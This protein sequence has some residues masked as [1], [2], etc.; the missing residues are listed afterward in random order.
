MT[1]EERYEVDMMAEKD[2]L[3]KMYIIDH[4]DWAFENLHLKMLEVKIQDYLTYLATE[5]AAQKYPQLE[6]V[7]IEIFFMK[8]ITQE[9]DRV[10]QL[11]ND[12]LEKQETNITISYSFSDE[13]E[14]KRFLEASNDEESYFLSYLKEIDYPTD[15]LFS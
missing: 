13:A 15:D 7:N 4:L 11:F 5:K 12:Q 8:G 14:S 2:G 9:A 3:V 6:R 10:I 1:I